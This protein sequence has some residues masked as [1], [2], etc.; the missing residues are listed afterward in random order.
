MLKRYIPKISHIVLFILK[1]LYKKYI[2]KYTCYYIKYKCSINNI[3]N[4]SM[5]YF[6]LL[7]K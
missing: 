1:N 5:K 6:R 4:Y 3:S 7:N 2:C